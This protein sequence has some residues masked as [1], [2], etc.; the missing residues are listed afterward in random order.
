MVV[1]IDIFRSNILTFEIN[2]IASCALAPTTVGISRMCC[3]ALLMRINQPG[4]TFKLIDLGDMIYIAILIRNSKH[5]S[6][7]DNEGGSLRCYNS[8]D[9]FTYNQPRIIS[10]IINMYHSNERHIYPLMA[11]CNPNAAVL[12]L[13]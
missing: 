12:P 13:R 1:S 8:G 11:E 6:D 10:S 4:E 7:R 5:R 3:L 2:Q 9:I